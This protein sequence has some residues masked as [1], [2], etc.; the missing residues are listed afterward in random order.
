MS[1]EFPPG[2]GGIGSHAFQLARQL[3]RRGWEVRV[4][5]PQDYAVDQDVAYFNEQQP[6]RILRLT[7]G[8]GWLR[9]TTLRFFALQKQI[10]EQK[11]DLLIATGK[12][13]AFLGAF[14]RH[15]F[16]LRLVAIGHGTEFGVKDFWHRLLARWAYQQADAVICVSHFTRGLLTKL[17]V[18]ARVSKVIQN[19]AD[20]ER[21]RRL[22]GSMQQ[23]CLPGMEAH[24][25]LIT[26]GS[27]TDRKGQEIVIRALPIILKEFPHTHYMIAGLPF[28]QQKLE[29]LARELDVA[30][31]VHFLGSVG[32]DELVKYLNSCDVFMMTSRSTEDGDCEGFGIAVVEAALCGKPAIV[33]ANSGL[34]EAII[35]GKT[36]IAV[37]QGDVDAT[38][39][40]V[41]RLLN[42][43]A[44]RRSMGQAAYIY[45]STQQTWEKKG[46]EFDHFLRGL[47]DPPLGKYIVKDSL[48]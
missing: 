40:A 4:L 10:R 36:G 35:D 5:T 17:G 27:V 41:L 42:N 43:P 22:S 31:H 26:V 6:F 23:D 38:A 48:Q 19:G 46:T 34:I 47:L 9:E 12:S 45:S 39:Q 44:R 37:P 7:S 21:F 3:H 1:S 13:A 33:S 32:N 28:I 15:V 16:G 8:G 14:G 29:R 20:H 24:H 25:I 2:P 30:D 11:A 18:K